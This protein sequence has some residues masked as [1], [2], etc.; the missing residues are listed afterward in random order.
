MVGGLIEHLADR[1]DGFSPS[2]LIPFPAEPWSSVRRS[3]E[4]ARSIEESLQVSKEDGAGGR[5][6]TYRRVGALDA[7]SAFDVLLGLTSR[8]KEAAALAPLGPKPI[9]LAFCLL[10][11]QSD[12]HPIYYAQPKAYAVNYSEGYEQTYAYWVKHEGENL[13][14]I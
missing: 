13:Y 2:I 8:G 9:S 4:S 6:P 5:T 14:A 10:A 3:W 1:T 12:K 11:S 7:S